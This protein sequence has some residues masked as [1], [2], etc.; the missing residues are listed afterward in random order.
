LSKKVGEYPQVVIRV[1]VEDKK[2]IKEFG[3]K[4]SDIWRLGFEKWIEELP[5]EMQKKAEYYQN[6]LLQCNDK[7][8]KCNDIVTTR[9]S[10]LDI[11]C[12]E[13]ISRGRSIDDPSDLDI[14]W[15]EARFSKHKL[16]VSLEKF[17]DRCK[18]LKGV[19]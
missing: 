10:V 14:N 18:E 5:S 6:M 12:E 13:Y 2:L 17:L 9:K 11:I 8:A 1:S 19:G 15:I 4:Y 7:I 16:T 3:G